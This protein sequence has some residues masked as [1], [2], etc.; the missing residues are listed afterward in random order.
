[1]L[2]YQP[3]SGN[4]QGSIVVS[5]RGL[6]TDNKRRDAKMH[7]KVLKSSPHPLITLN[8]LRADGVLDPET[9]G[10]L[11]LEAELILLGQAHPL[12]FPVEIS[13]SDMENGVLLA[14]GAFMVP[15][16]AWGLEDPSAVFLRVDKEVRVSFSAAGTLIPVP[17]P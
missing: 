16:V 1:V 4:L 3:A 11:Q 7:E 14:T 6:T 10:A 8:I 17:A 9:G 2:T 13:V 12:S 5:A 15:Y